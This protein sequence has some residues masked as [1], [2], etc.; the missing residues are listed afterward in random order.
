MKICFLMYQGNMYSGGQGVYLHYLTRELARMGHE[1]HVIAGPPYPTLDPAVITHNVTDYSYWTYH[2]YKKDFIFNRPPLSYFHPVNLYDF[3]STRIALSSLL[4]NFSVRAYFRLRELAR[5]HRFDVV[6]DNQTLSYGVW[7]VKATGFPLVAT[8]HHPLSADL[9]NQLRQARSTYEKARRILWSPWI[10]QEVVAKRADRIIVVSETSR[11]DVD[12]AFDLDPA[13]VRVVY[14]GI[15]TDT[16][17]PL[18][19]VERQPDKLLYVGNSEDRNKGAR[20]FLKA[21]DLLKD[22]LDF[23]VTFVDNFKHNLKLAPR[24]VD[25]YG[26]NSRVDFT[27]RIPTE[28]LVRHYNEAKLLVTSSVHEGFG[29]PLAEAMSCGTPV[30]GTQIGAFRE[31]VEHDVSGWLVPPSSPEALASAIRMMWN[32]AELRGRL[33]EA[34]RK[35]ILEK[36]NWRK[37]AEETLAVYEEIVPPKRRTFTTNYELQTTN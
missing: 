24:L 11:G 14:N 32:D 6:H 15:D 27:G 22:E 1:V 18:P 30:V 10:M 25:E 34:G 31:I 12:E 21:L 19:G 4:A 35:R 36:F 8:I 5:E 16:F 23:R 26:L 3:I 20:Y 33:G 29:L 13:K 9:K 2:H 37:A 17:R 28:D 7:A